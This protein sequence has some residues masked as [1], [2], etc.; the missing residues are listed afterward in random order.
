M[1]GNEF[2]YF[3]GNLSFD[4]LS[5]GGLGVTT[6]LAK[7]SFAFLLLSML[8]YWFQASFKYNKETFLGKAPSLTMCLANIALALMLSIRWI[9]SGHFPLSNLYESL[10]FLSWS[11]TSIH[12]FL[13]RA[14]FKGELISPTLGAITAPLALFTNAFATFSL[15]QEMQ[16]VTVLV[17]ALQ[18]NWLIMHV[19]V[20]MIS[21]AALLSG[22]LLAMAF[23]VV[24]FVEE[25]LYSTFTVGDQRS[26]GFTKG[27]VCD[28]ESPSF[29]S[30]TVKVG[31][32]N[33]FDSSSLTTS[34]SQ[35]TEGAKK[36]MR[37]DKEDYNQNLQ[38]FEFNKPQNTGIFDFPLKSSLAHFLESSIS[39]G[40]FNLIKFPILKKN[41]TQSEPSSMASLKSEVLWEWQSALDKTSSK[42]REI[43]W[44]D[45]ILNIPSTEL[46]QSEQTFQNKLKQTLDNLSYRSIGLG[47]A[48]LTIGIFSGAV[49][50]NEAWGS[51]WSWDPKETWA[52][53]TWL[54][55]A[56]YL[57]TRLS[58]GWVGKESAFVAA[59]GF[60]VIWFC[61]LGVNLFGKGLHSYGWFPTK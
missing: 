58:R 40:F 13:E 42:Q 9:E 35:C 10:L 24:K 60:L 48:L 20:M 11:L 21:Y 38:L 39:F 30:P 32:V 26:S 28:V 61:Y 34:N 54:V 14:F 5:L 56:L 19:S 57:H 16:K 50:A 4:P 6:L 29:T 51:Y 7:S 37:K 27:D 43:S 18:S 2:E 25:T 3:L 23:L 52:F 36:V 8:F 55:F 47:F 17:P 15:P 45:T 41:E 44:E 49:W 46:N 1:K 59:L 33:L 53:V 12:F 22:S 31:D